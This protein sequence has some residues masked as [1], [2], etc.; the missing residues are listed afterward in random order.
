MEAGSLFQYLTTL[1]KADPFLVRQL[2][3]RRIL[4]GCTLK[5]G[6]VGENTS[7]FGSTSSRPVNTLNVN[8]RSPQTRRS[9]K[10]CRL[11]GYKPLLAQGIMRVSYLPCSLPLNWLQMVGI[12]H[13]V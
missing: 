6:R 1:T 11:S 4:W 13:E 5:Q 3:L 2:L 8:T 12:C 7:K 10:E 9:C